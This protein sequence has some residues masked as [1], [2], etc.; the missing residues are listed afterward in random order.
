M[1]ATPENP[2]MGAKGPSP[3]MKLE[4]FQMINGFV[5]EYQHCVCLGVTRQLAKL[6]FDSRNHN[7][8]W[9][10]GTRSEHIDKELIAV[11]PLVEITQVPRSVADRTFWKVSEW[12]SFLL[13]ALSILN[14]VLLKNFWIHLFLLVFAMH[15]LLGEKVKRCDIEVAERALKKFTMQFEKLYGAANMKFNV[16]LLTHI[17]TGVRNWGPLW[18]TS[19]FSFES[20]NGTL[21]H[22]FHGTTHVP[23]QIVKSFLCW[24][25][26]TLKAE[27]Y[28]ADANDG[29]KNIFS[30]LL[31]TNLSTSNSTSL[32]ENV[33][34]FGSPCQG[35]LSVLQKLAIKDL[36]G[37]TVGH[38][39]CY[40]CFVI[41]G[42]LYHSSRN[43]SLKK[44]I[45]STVEVQDGRLCRILSMA[46]FRT[47]HLSMQCVLVKELMK[48]GR[49]LCRDGQL[50]IASTF[51]SEVL[52][53]KNVYAVPTDLFYR[54][55]VL[56]PTRDKEFVIP[57]PNHMERD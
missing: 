54:K 40:H 20:F 35:K 28:M 42:I 39:V 29:V 24:R 52:E 5:P 23:E 50:N 46:V 31:N 19:T 27:K 41:K 15:I 18:A 3:L 45:N 6:W 2:V 21:L 16:H 36:L 57:L 55:C 8:E 43:R 12:R 7:K 14:G 4:K 49:Q 44:R 26:L 30:G 11:Q 56:I 48:T 10:I 38:C 34:V 37:V 51:V 9:D 32:N 1:A 53:T 25:N 33:R 17:A 13:F 22:Y 47:E